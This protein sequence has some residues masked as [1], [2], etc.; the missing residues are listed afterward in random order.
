MMDALYV[1]WWRCKGEKGWS[2]C[3][4][5]YSNYYVFLSNTSIYISTGKTVEIIALILG[6]PLKVPDGIG[7]SFTSSAG[8]G[9]GTRGKGVKKKTSSESLLQVSR[10]TL[11]VVPPTLLG[12]WWRELHLRVNADELSSK[13][14]EVINVSASDSRDF[15]NVSV[16]IGNVVQVTHR[17]GTTEIL[18]DM[19]RE[20][21]ANVPFRLGDMVHFTLPW[22]AKSKVL[23]LSD[24]IV[25]AYCFNVSCTYAHYIHTII[26]DSFVIFVISLIT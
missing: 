8:G 17:D 19:S 6:N 24:Y 16:D 22:G 11:I 2:K 4:G 20:D 9:D 15:K 1:V 18:Q 12:Q 7:S 14:F 26:T 5:L 3:H 10:A 13:A 23:R 25:S 21:K